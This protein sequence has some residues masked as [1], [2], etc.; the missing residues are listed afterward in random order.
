MTPFRVGVWTE[1]QRSSTS[2]RKEKSADDDYSIMLLEM[3]GLSHRKR[4]IEAPS[5]KWFFNPFLF[6][7]ILFSLGGRD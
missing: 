2:T 4:A 3:P 6:Q 7:R 1:L 5:I